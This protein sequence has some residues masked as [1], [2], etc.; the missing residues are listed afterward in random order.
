MPEVRSPLVF[1][2]LLLL[3]TKHLCL[4]HFQFRFPIERIL[5]KQAW[6]VPLLQAISK[7]SARLCLKGGKKVREEIQ[8]RETALCE[9][10]AKYVT[11]TCS[12]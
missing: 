9:A 11:Q 6:E 12:L 8:A 1:E 3:F 2:L 7:V 5:Y 4:L 10:R